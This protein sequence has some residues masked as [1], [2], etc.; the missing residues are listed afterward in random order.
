MKTP[1][2]NRDEVREVSFTVMAKK[3]EK[4]AY[5]EA[6]DKLG[7]TRSAWIRMV[8]NEKINQK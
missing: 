4:D 5:T 2:K 6:G 1:N 7:L 3:A 8:L